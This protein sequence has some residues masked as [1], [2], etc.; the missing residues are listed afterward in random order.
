MIIPIEKA[1]NKLNDVNISMNS[2]A[3][4]PASE[5]S[6]TTPVCPSLKHGMAQ[7]DLPLDPPPSYTPYRRQ[8]PAAETSSRVQPT[9]IPRACN[10]LSLSRPNSAIRGTYAI[11][12]DLYIPPSLLPPLG[13]DES[14][15]DRKNLKL[16]SS[17]GAIDIDIFL[18]GQSPIDGANP[19]RRTLMD[20]KSANGTVNV[21]LVRLAFVSAPQCVLYM[22]LSRTPSQ[23][24]ATPFTSPPAPLMAP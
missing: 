5:V 6:L 15:S 13:W 10:Y 18:L 14:E 2:D 9:G 16:M 7:A 23:H 3:R 20:V 17:N 19:S 12:P 11:N 1:S 24:L 8:Q 22:A 4:Q 21:K